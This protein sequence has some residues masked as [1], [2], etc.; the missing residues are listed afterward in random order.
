MADVNA[1]SGGLSEDAAKALI[2][3]AIAALPA[4]A[5][6]FVRS[7]TP[8]TIADLM[9]S[10]PAG[11]TYSGMYARV[12]NLYNGN[13]ASSAGGIDEIL[14]CRFDERNMI[15]R[16]MPQRPDYNTEVAA[17]GNNLM[18]T[19]LVTPPTVRLTGTLLGNLAVTPVALNAYVGQKFRVIQNSTL[20]LFATTLTGLLGSNITLLGNTVQDLEY[21]I[22]GWSK[23]ST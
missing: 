16:W 12:S 14:R 20:G 11:S 15:Y 19:P 18:L 23:A 5:T 2:A 3:S 7:G 13:T 8:M 22:Q 9:T 17:T 1:G 21:T 4:P 6:N 10:Y